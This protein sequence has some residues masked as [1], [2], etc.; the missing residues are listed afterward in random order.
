[1]IGTNCAIKNHKKARL[2]KVGSHDFRVSEVTA[3]SP[4]VIVERL[5]IQKDIYI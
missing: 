2:S 4:Y 5:S 1:M 3:S